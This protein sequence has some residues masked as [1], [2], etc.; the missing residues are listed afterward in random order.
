MR[1][2][3]L[4]FSLS[5]IGLTNSVIAQSGISFSGPSKSFYLPAQ[6]LK[7][8]TTSL[9]IVDDRGI[10]FLNEEFQSVKE[11]RR[12]NLKQLPIGYYTISFET[13]HRRVSYAVAITADRIQTLGDPTTLY[14]PFV[15]IENGNALV[16]LLNLNH[17]VSLSFLDGHGNVLYENVSSTPVTQLSLNLKNVTQGLY[18]LVVAYPG[19]IFKTSIDTAPT[20]AQVQVSK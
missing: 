9:D 3:F 12:Y 8:T 1:T 10:Q 13:S 4:I 5:M 15:R 2:L 11:G 6:Q 20:M 14:K 7:E 17:E 18:H 16:N 19:C